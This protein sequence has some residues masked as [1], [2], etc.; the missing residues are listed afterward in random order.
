MPTTSPS[1]DATATLPVPPS[2]W[3]NQQQRGVL[4]QMW[5]HRGA[6]DISVVSAKEYKDTQSTDLEIGRC[7]DIVLQ[8]TNVVMSWTKQIWRAWLAH[9]FSFQWPADWGMNTDS[10][11]YKEAV[12]Q[13]QP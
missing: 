4:T 8:Q 13:N 5:R 3:H 12:H 9:G 6:S 10:V 1:R 11:I 7:D 2:A